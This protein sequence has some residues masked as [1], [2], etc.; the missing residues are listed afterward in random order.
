MRE[1][2][3]SFC[4]E[5]DHPIEATETLLSAYDQLK[6]SPEA[7]ALFN[8]Q[9]EKYNTDKLTD[10][11]EA[12]AA[13]DKAAE[14]SGVHRYTLHLMLYI[15]LSKHTR[16]LYKKKNIPMSIYHDSMSDLK[17]K[18][19]E[20]HKMYGIWGSFVAWWF[21]RFFDLT[22]FALGRLQ[23]ETVQFNSSY[24]KDGYILNHGDIVINV[25]IPSC[26]PLK[27]DAC[28][29]SYKMAAEFYKD[30]FIDRPVA[31]K[32]ESW[33][34]Y[35]KHR[36]FL[37]RTSNILSFMNDYDIFE[38]AIDEKNSD[39][40]RIFYKESTDNLD[41]LPVET[42]IQRAYID[43]FRKGNK[44]GSGEGVFF[45]ADLNRHPT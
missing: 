40:W 16:E 45:I 41:E 8:E 9:V 4:K 22:R 19:F 15:C 25:H 42:S 26:G 14:I 3:K 28:L 6:K 20:C 17:W 7:Y 13:M 38:S 18:L 24:S 33:L 1:Y 29:E 35:P 39:A 30:I 32:C 2:I 37:P 10:H 36:E 12:L 44:M 31:I 43:W 21:I 27:H 5:F 23:F 34:L 11:Y